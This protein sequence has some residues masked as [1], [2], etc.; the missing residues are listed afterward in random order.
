[1]TDLG[2]WDIYLPILGAILSSMAIFETLHLGLGYL[3][4]KQQM[5][6]YLEFQ[7]KLQSGE[8]ELPP[9]LM[10]MSGSPMGGP[11]GMFPG[12]MPPTQG[13]PTVSGEGPGQYL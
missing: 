3:Q 10:Q 8:I 7:E 1:M 5:Q 11:M 6:K 13:D 12:M 9:E 4:A 2:F